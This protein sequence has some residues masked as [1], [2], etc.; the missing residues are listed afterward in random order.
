MKQGKLCGEVQEPGDVELTGHGDKV[1]FYPYCDGGHWRIWAQGSHGLIHIFYD[2]IGST[3]NVGVS[4]NT[5]VPLFLW[6]RWL[7]IAQ[8]SPLLGSHMAVIKV[9]MGLGSQLETP[10]KKNPFSSFLRFL[11]KLFFLYS[12]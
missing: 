1:E 10:L 7:C 9:W 3:T 11:S 2:C 12:K 6:A 5:L 8:A 4:N